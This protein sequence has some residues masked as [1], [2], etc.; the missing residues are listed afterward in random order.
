M[1]NVIEILIDKEKNII[2]I[3]LPRITL[4]D[5]IIKTNKISLK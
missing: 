1:H 4:E 3:V 2:P 5:T